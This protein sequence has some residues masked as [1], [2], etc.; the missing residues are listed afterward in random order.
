MV[1]KLEPKRCADLA[2]STYGTYLNSS[3]FFQGPGALSMNRFQ[4]LRGK[5]NE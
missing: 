3:S 4:A 5:E 2:S 1:L